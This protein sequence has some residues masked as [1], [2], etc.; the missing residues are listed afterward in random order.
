VRFVELADWRLSK[1]G[2]GTAQFANPGWGYGSAHRPHEIAQRAIQLGVNHFDT[3][4][5]YGAGHSERIL[6]AVL[7]GVVG[8]LVATKVFNLAPSSRFVAAQVRASVERLGGPIGLCYLAWGNPFVDDRSAMGAMR[9]MQEAGLV[10]EVGVGMFDLPRWQAAERS[11]GRP[12]LVNQVAYNLLQRDAETSLLPWAAAEGRLIV[13]AQ[14][15]ATGFLSGD[16]HRGKPVTGPWRQRDPRFGS[17]HV[18]R[19]A[20]LV[21]AL[22][23][24][25]RAHGATPA[26]VALAYVLRHP[27]VVAV[28]GAATADQLAENVEAVDLELTRDECRWLADAS[29]GCTTQVD[30][31]SRPGLQAARRWAKGAGLLAATAKE[32][33]LLRYHRGSGTDRSMGRVIRPS[34]TWRGQGRWARRRG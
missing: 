34:R 1:V 8:L 13:A 17:D 33:R 28:P 18:Q 3:A 23:D 25:G 11:L 22:G 7:G 10:A 30:A 24:V 6:A 19:T 14:P 2:L 16:Y 21:G 32:D 26:Q 20:E 15:L 31:A 29:D 9:R 4:G 27:N 12:I 5:Y